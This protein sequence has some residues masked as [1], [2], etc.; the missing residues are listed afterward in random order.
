HEEIMASQEVGHSTWFR[1]C[2]PIISV[3]LFVCGDD[4]LEVFVAA[5]R[6]G[7]NQLRDFAIS[8]LASS[9]S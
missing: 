5:V 3:K 2:I 4:F 7:D 1:S 8:G 6:V 9:F